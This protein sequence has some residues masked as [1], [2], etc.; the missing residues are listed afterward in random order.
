MITAQ[1][2]DHKARLRSFEIV[3]EVRDSDVAERAAA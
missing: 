1:I 2:F 3:A